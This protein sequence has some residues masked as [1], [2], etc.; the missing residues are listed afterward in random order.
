MAGL[1]WIDRGIQSTLYLLYAAADIAFIVEE[2][3]Q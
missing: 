2:P 3:P 1:H